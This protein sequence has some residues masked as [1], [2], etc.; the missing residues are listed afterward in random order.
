MTEADEDK[1]KPF[2]TPLDILKDYAET[3][4]IQGLPYLVF[5]YQTRFGKFFWILVVLTMLGL[6]KFHV[7]MTCFMAVDHSARGIVSKF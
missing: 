4:T 2:S 5:S 6:G 7:L 3:S 1:E